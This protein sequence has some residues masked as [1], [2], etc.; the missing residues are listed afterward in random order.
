MSQ[1]QFLSC[2]SAPESST[3]ISFYELLGRI[4]HNP[5]KKIIEHLH[6]LTKGSKEYDD[7]KAGLPCIKPHGTFDRYCSSEKFQQAS[8]YIYFDVDDALTTKEQLLNDYGHLISVLGHSVGGKCLFFL[9]KVNR[10][11]II[12]SANFLDIQNKVQSVFFAD[13]PIDNNGKGVNRNFIIPYDKNVY[14]NSNAVINI[15]SFLYD[16]VQQGITSDTKERGGV[17]TTYD[18]SFNIKFLGI[19][20][21]LPLIKWKTQIEVKE[22]K[23]DYEICEHDAIKLF[24]PQFIQDGCKHKSFNRIVNAIVFNNPSLEFIHVISFINYVNR[25]HT[26]NPMKMREMIFT[27]RREYNRLIETRE[28]KGLKKKYVITNPSLR[29]AERQKAG[30]KGWGEYRRNMSLNLLNQT[31]GQLSAEGFIHVTQK[32]VIERLKGKMGVAT[33]K[34]YWKSV[35]SRKE[36]SKK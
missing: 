8:G 25:F 21:V 35:I 14:F 4:V 32:M 17:N 20:E 33:I 31:V 9:V 29:S 1:F 16:K 13:L 11:E 24:I 22:W 7:I 28:F 19:N 6:S 3:T 27:V 15:D 18:T 30:A 26:T 5:N 23:S 34:R 2:I 12:N 10:P 36:G